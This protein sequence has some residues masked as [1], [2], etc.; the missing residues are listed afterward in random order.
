MRNTTI[1]LFAFL[2][3]LTVSSLVRAQDTKPAEQK[4]ETPVTDSEKP[5]NEVDEKIAE[6]NKRGEKVQF[7]TG[8]KKPW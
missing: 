7:R 4:S 1:S 3:I 8:N 5:K 2:V 6:V